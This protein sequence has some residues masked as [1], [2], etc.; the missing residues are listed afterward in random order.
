MNDLKYALR[1][2]TRTPGFTAI[3]LLT[4]ALGIGANTAI[5]SIVNGVLLRPL[6]FRDEGRLVRVFTSTANEPKS[7]H[8][9]GDFLD[10]QR[11]N[12]TL[13]AI[14]G[15]RSDIVAVAPPAGDPHQLEASYVTVDFFDVLGAP[16]AQGRTFTRAQDA[17]SAEPM[18]VL[19]Q[20]AARNMFGADPEVAGRRVRV[21]GQPY[22]IAGVMPGGFAWPEGVQIWILS[23]KPVPPTPLDIKG[24]DPLTDREVAYFEAI[25][26]LKPGVSLADAQKDLHA[27]ALG[28]QHLHAQ[29]NGNRDIRVVSL[30]DDMVGDVRD[31]LLLLQAAVGIVLLIACA[32]VSSL[33]IARSTGRRR[34]LAIR[35]A[36]GA[37][38]GRLIAQL[39]TESLALGVAGGLLGLLLGS[40][41][42]V[43]LVR[44]LPDSVPRGDTVT[45]DQTVSIVTVIVSLIA[46]AL[47]G[48]LPAIQA[49]RANASV[50]LKVTGDRGGTGRARGRATLVVA[51]VALTLVLLVAAGLLG[52][53]LLR[54]Q[55]V[56]PGFRAEHVTL[57]PLNVPQT[58]YATSEQQAA[59]FTRLLDRL[60]ARSGLQAVG[61]GFPGPFRGHNASGSFLIEG[62]AALTRADRPFAHL[63]SVSG[64][65]FAAM[66]IPL[67]AGRTFTPADTAEAPPVAIVN[68]A[69]AKKYW[70]G[71]DPLGKHLRFDPN[72]KEPW[73]TIVGLVGDVHQLGLAEDAPPLL[74]LPYQQFSLP[75]TQ[76]TIRSTLPVATVT[77]LMRTELAALDRDLAFGD[78]MSLQ[79]VVDQSMDQPRF[80]TVLIGLFA[81]LALV[82]AAIGVYGLI[83]YTV[84]QRTREIGI[85]VALGAH[86]RQ[87]LASVIRDGLVLAGLGI[88]CGLVA[89]VL[90][91][92]LLSSFLFGV[93]ATD[94]ATFIGVSILLVAVAVAAS[95]IPSR[96]A[97]RVD[98]LIALRAE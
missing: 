11:N 40:W 90:A 49:S 58:R 18:V 96:R 93:G 66:G 6:P 56:D 72:P 75:F 14:A 7:N 69:L 60:T 27:I 77:S 80:R 88:G 15:M 79:S 98:P 12:R 41:L 3:A 9:A 24:I 38:R 51:E 39:L 57:A 54:L 48:L 45:L 1:T 20:T 33:L 70:P 47:F 36:I 89:A 32:N 16:A 83:S 78:V 81:L 62:R 21:N 76:I 17:K 5:F 85:R 64:G 52:N 43:V 65:Y 46:G 29:T 59:L 63:G 13:Q 37:G 53:S 50:A 35:A 55:R 84:T 82:L 74:Y 8:S 91:S 71:D 4:I 68:V 26:R 19:A 28:L 31:A 42:V 61:I 92:R 23:Q 87:V 30:R 97:L 73:F 10:L 95:Y 2:L 22:T 25:G 67:I 94:P 44:I 34:E 86:P